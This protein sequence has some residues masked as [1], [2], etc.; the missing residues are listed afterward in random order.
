MGKGSC[1]SL[2]I[3]LGSKSEDRPF[4]NPKKEMVKMLQKGERLLML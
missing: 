1:S 4:L 3:F 2:K